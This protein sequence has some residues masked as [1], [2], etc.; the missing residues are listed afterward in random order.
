M[1]NCMYIV[2]MHLIFLSNVVFAIIIPPVAPLA[3]SSVSTVV[4]DPKNTSSTEENSVAKAVV[5]TVQSSSKPSVPKNVTPPPK[6]VTK[7]I[8]APAKTAPKVTAKIVPKVIV[9][10]A[11]H[12]VTPP[13]KVA[14][15][16]T[17]STKTTN[18]QTKVQTIN[19]TSQSEKTQ[20]V[21]RRILIQNTSKYPATLDGLTVNYSINNK[22]YEHKLSFSDSHILKPK[23]KKSGPVI[24]RIKEITV[25][26]P[27]QA[28]GTILKISSVKING[29]DV[30]IKYKGLD[31]YPGEPTD[32]IYVT[33]GNGS[34]WQLDKKAM[35]SDYAKINRVGG[36][37][38]NKSN[39]DN[40]QRITK[41]TQAAVLTVVQKKNNK[42]LKKQSKATQAVEKIS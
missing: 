24:A 9:P 20:L 22:N 34:T 21:I 10:P 31:W 11:V 4:L 40:A 15:I 23:L 16:V 36:L 38:N 1:K 18:T 35:D 12:V 32:V 30:S 41:T 27:L 25:A 2:M 39:V 7:V 37:V 17:S 6:I 28:A 42:K 14:P 29:K 3:H 13:A 33:S 5:N 26:A 8:T 19:R